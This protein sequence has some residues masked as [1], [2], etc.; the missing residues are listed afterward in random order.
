MTTTT[1]NLYKNTPVENEKKESSFWGR[2]K[3]YF[4]E[5]QASIVCG[6]LTMNGSTNVSGLYRSLTETE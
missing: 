6:M 5:S 1:A 2:C 3:G 4:R